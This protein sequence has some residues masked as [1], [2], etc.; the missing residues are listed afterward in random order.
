[1]KIKA[2][3]FLEIIFSLLLSTLILAGTYNYF[4]AKY[5]NPYFGTIQKTSPLNSLEQNFDVIKN[6][7]EK[8]AFFSFFVKK[9]LLIKKIKGVT[10][11][12]LGTLEVSP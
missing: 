1:M 5:S 7:L 11:T 8:M 12:D 4:K 3:S 10:Y 6:Y 9:F 2:F